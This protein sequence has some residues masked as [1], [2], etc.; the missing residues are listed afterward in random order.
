[1]FI[2]EKM[3]LELTEYAKIDGGENLAVSMYSAAVQM[4]ES[5]TGKAF[6]IQDEKPKDQLYWLAIMM[7]VAHWY[8][9]RGNGSDK[10]FYELPRSA[11][12]ILNHI[13]LSTDFEKIQ[14]AAE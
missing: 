7:M 3:K 8:D 14:E 5:E 10:A 9:N 4:A 13:A 12:T 1:M 11:Q 6:I 2:S